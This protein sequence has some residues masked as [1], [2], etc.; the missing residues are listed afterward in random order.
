M[1]LLRFC[2][3]GCPLGLARSP[4]WIRS[5]RH[6][7][8][9]SLAWIA[10]VYVGV[11]LVL[12]ALENRFLFYPVTQAQEW[13]PPPPSLGKVLDVELTSADGTP[14]HG[15]WAAPAGWVAEDGALLYCHGNA[16][17]LSHRGGA[18]VTW[19]QELH[20]AVLIFDYPGYGRS[21]GKPDEAGCYAAGEAACEWLT[22]LQKIPAE[23]VIL[24]GESLGGAVATELASRRPHRALVL[25][26]AFTS[27]PDMAQKE[28]PWLPARW[29]VRNRMD[30]L[31]KIGHTNRPVFI[32]HGTADRLI[33]FSQGERLFAAAGEP[34][35]FFPMP[36]QDHNDPPSVA[37]YAALRAFLAQ[38]SC[39]PE[40]QRR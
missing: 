13:W 12:L 18:L 27:F 1:L 26:S 30:N 19:H 32:A 34:R 24:Y 33:P 38:Q 5:W 2:Y 4:F 23:R 35:Q 7:L 6:R 37:F 40:A 14:L 8:G 15:W 22:E 29:L 16:G 10:Y 9:R 25:V 17:N 28:F 39:A 3:L 20:T 11:L 21:G 36:G 31:S